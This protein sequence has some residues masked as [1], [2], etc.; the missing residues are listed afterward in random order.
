MAWRR[1][2]PNRQ[3]YGELAELIRDQMKVLKLEGI[4]VTS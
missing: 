4:T 1:Q 3:G 2:A